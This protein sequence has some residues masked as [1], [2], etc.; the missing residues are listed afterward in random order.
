MLKE[1]L[2]TIFTKFGKD[3]IITLLIGCIIGLALSKAETLE[4][5]WMNFILML[6]FCMSVVF[7]I[8]KREILLLLV[9]FFVLPLLFTYHP[10]HLKISG[11]HWPHEG[12]VI[13]IS[14]IPFAFLFILW[15][16]RLIIDPQETINF[17]PW[18]SFPYLIIWIIAIAGISRNECP[19]LVFYTS[20]AFIFK[21]WL[22]FI[23]VANN[24]KKSEIIY[25]VTVIL[26]LTLAFQVMI[27]SLQYIKG[28]PLGLEKLGELTA[29][30]ESATGEVGTVSRVGGT[31]GSPN[32]FA[33]FIHMLLPVVLSL[34]FAK[35][36]NAYKLILLPL[37][38]LGGVILLITYSRGG[39]AGF[40]LGAVIIVYWNLVRINGRKFFNLLFIACFGGVFF[41]TTVLFVESVRNR[42]FEDDHGSSLVRVLL[43]S[44][45]HNMIRQNPFLGIGIGNYSQVIEKYDNSGIYGV[46]IYFPWP[47][48]NEYLLIASELGLP[49]LALFIFILLVIFVNLFRIGNSHTDPIIPYIGIGF[50]GSFVAFCFHHRY[51]YVWFFLQA[52]IWANIGLIQAMYQFTKAKAKQKQNISCSDFNLD[53]RL[54]LK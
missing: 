52:R 10:I 19:P 39:W 27:G 33:G 46:S 16:Y 45:A 37:L 20:I 15:L 3:I 50:F 25:W 51:E 7:I 49:A 11:I 21:N 4:P 47:V 32:K 43:E 40:G 36:D 9:F 44:V 24:L 34:L 22:I 6:C 31:I 13:F 17:Y 30:K 35:I 2:T 53:H 12:T 8:P 42:L 1:K 26:I 48:H 29:I 41:I 23:F 18:I 5:K 38:I 14:D 54:V 28:G